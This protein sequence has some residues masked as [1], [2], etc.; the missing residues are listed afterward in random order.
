MSIFKYF[1]STT[2]I[3]NF[4]NVHIYIHFLLLIFLYNKLG[5]REDKRNKKIANERSIFI[6]GGRKKRERASLKRKYLKQKD[7]K[8][9][10]KLLS[11]REK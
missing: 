6:H 2:F 5:M 1:K 4:K 9:T 8:Q 11:E 7:K 3:L 10:Q